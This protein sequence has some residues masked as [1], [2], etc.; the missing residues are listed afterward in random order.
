VVQSKREAHEDAIRQELTRL[1]T[2]LAQH[3]EAMKAQKQ[4]LE[5]LSSAYLDQLSRKADLQMALTQA[6]ASR[7]G[8]VMQHAELLLFMTGSES[9][10]N[11][12]RS[13]SG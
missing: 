4:R 1:E 12:R 13:R 5:S 2:L 9:H 3:M 7:H 10:P 8:A 11:D 6:C